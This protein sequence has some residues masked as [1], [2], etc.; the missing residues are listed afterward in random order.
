MVVIFVIFAPDRGKNVKRKTKE[1]YIVTNRKW[2]IW[3]IVERQ[4]VQYRW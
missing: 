4:Q 3:L 2:L 1:T